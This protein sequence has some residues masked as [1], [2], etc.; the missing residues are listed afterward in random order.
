[1]KPTEK[2]IRDG[3]K[4]YTKWSLTGYNLFVLGLTC[5]Y[6]WRC[7]SALIEAHYNNHVSDNHLDV[8]VGT[9]YFL[10]R[11][12]FPSKTPRVGLMDINS[13]S[14]GFT[15]NTIARYNPETYKQNILEPVSMKIQS[16]D[17]IGIN[18]LLHCIPGTIS[19]KAVAF[20]YL[21]SILNR[22]GVFFGATVLWGGVPKNGLTKRIMSF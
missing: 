1:M 10:D 12:I 5:S 11:C 14:L 22:N 15:S 7:P 6:I 4:I 16:F 13:D 3:Q 9:G 21:K 18:Y 20:D 2:Q 17:S 19:E 8:G